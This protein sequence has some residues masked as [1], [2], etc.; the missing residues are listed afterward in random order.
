MPGMRTC[1][2]TLNSVTRSLTVKP[3][4]LNLLKARTG[5]SQ[6]KMISPTPELPGPVQTAAVE[7]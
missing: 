1:M 6:G 5:C 2:N 3:P 7:K 4:N